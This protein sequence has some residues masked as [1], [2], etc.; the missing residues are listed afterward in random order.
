M[1]A[2]Q[3]DF[4]LVGVNIGIAE[5]K[6]QFFVILIFQTGRIPDTVG[7]GNPRRAVFV[8]DG[9]FVKRQAEAQFPLVVK[10]ITGADGIK[11]GVFPVFF[12]ETQVG[13][14]FA[15]DVEVFE[16]GPE[17]PAVFS[18][19]RPAVV[20]LMINA[21]GKAGRSGQTGGNVLIETV[22]SER[23]ELRKQTAGS[24]CAVKGN[25]ALQFVADLAAVTEA[26]PGFGRKFVQRTQ[27]IA[28]VKRVAFQAGVVFHRAERRCLTD[29]VAENGLD[30]LDLHAGAESQFV[31][32]LIGDH[33]CNRGRRH[34]GNGA[35]KPAGPAAVV[36]GNHAVRNVKR[37][38]RRHF[39]ADLP[40]QV[41]VRRHGSVDDV[42]DIAAFVAVFVK[43]VFGRRPRRNPGAARVDMRARM[44]G[45]DGGVVERVGNV[46][47][48]GG[49][50]GKS[51]ALSGSGLFFEEKSGRVGF[52]TG[53]NRGKG[54]Q[55][56]KSFHFKISCSKFSLAT[57]RNVGTAAGLIYYLL[58]SAVGI[59]VCKK[60]K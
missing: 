9:A 32:C 12:G 18:H 10:L 60:T 35:V 55:S 52:R 4:A 17:N 3:A 39:V 6:S 25:V 36:F 43:S 51:V 45:E 5:V 34:L 26:Y 7:V 40:R 58:C 29:A 16:F 27:L 53:K 24:H 47:R 56:H 15:D 20:Q 14:V 48:A 23:A 2:A 31:T 30:V 59:S 44:P 21:G 8:A 42:V 11:V 13:R 33:R 28:D 38:A 22:R 57:S 37:N 50:A 1:V 49:G 54:G 41:K 46:F 19:Y